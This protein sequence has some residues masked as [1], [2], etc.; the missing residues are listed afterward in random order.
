M[1]RILHTA[2]LHLDSPFSSL[3]V[4]EAARRREGLRGV[5]A[6][7]C[8][9][10]RDEKPDLFLIAGDLFDAQFVTRD[11]MDLIRSEFEKIPDTYVFIAPGN[12]DPFSPG[13]VWEKFDLP[14][15]V[16]VFRSQTLKRVSL[17][18][19]NVDVYGFAFTSPV[20]RNSPLVGQRAADPT[21]INILV[22]HTQLDDPLSPYAPISRDQLAAFGADYAALGHVHEASGLE[23]EAGRC[24]F[25]YSGCPEGRSF[26]EC[27]RKYA[28]EVSVDK[29]AGVAGVKTEKIYLSKRRYEKADVDVTGAAGN[30]DAREMIV[31]ALRDAGY[32]ENTALRLRLIGQTARP[33]T[34][35][36]IADSLG[37]ASLEIKDE[38]LA[39]LNA[40]LD[41]DRT[42]RGEFY[43]AIK[44]RLESADGR[45][46]E[47]A[48]RALKYALF[49][50]SGE[51]IPE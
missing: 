36:G 42:I 12:H 47:I 51:D 1:I 24:R 29:V 6:A 35:E 22:A 11:T 40:G 28:L 14:E 19:K 38:T 15:N 50:M 21:K 7:L 39:I 44:P 4:S 46:R 23:G 26:D 33:L 25:A 48:S 9:R 30:A 13:S 43:R 2:D 18:D 16:C 17:A 37:V 3:S 45:E 27:G 41:E 5:F 32:D 20:M 31:R 49:A 34:F 8:A 10:A